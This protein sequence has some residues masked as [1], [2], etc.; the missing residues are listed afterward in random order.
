MHDFNITLMINKE[1]YENYV[2]EDKKIIIKKWFNEGNIFLNNNHKV[3]LVQFCCT[4]DLNTYY[5]QI[6]NL[7]KYFNNLYICN[8][9]NDCLKFEF[10][11]MNEDLEKAINDVLNA[12]YVYYVENLYKNPLIIRYINDTGNIVNDLDDW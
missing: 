2:I 5:I 9:L 12:Y 3:K 4:I 1:N 10:D 7:L 6:S 8:K 11:Y